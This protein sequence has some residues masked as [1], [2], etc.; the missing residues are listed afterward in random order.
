[1]NKDFVSLPYIEPDRDGII[2][3]GIN[4][5]VGFDEER[6]LVN[7]KM[8]KRI[9]R[10]AGLGGI[11]VIGAEGKTNEYSTNISSMSEDGSATLG[12][13]VFKKK[14]SFVNGVKVQSWH[15]SETWASYNDRPIPDKYRYAPVTIS[16]NITERDERLRDSDKYKNGL[17]DPNGHAYF[18]DETLSKG[19]LEATKQRSDQAPNSWYGKIFVPAVVL[20]NGLPMLQGQDYSVG[21]LARTFAIWGAMDYAIVYYLQRKNGDSIKDAQ[22]SCAFGLDRRLAAKAL[23]KYSKLVKAQK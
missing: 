10:I 14:S 4:F 20:F 5:P 1:M 3:D 21:G 15:E 22:L 12:A 7:T 11:T 18:L 8:I 16:A 17:Y 13:S 23:S 9:A 2:F 19:L 6:L